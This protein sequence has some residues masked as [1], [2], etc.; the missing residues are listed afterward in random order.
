M[1][2]S[3]RDKTPVERAA[4]GAANTTQIGFESNGAEIACT[5]RKMA[6]NE[7]LCV[8]KNIILDVDAFESYIF[9]AAKSR[10]PNRYAP[11]TDGLSG[12]LTSSVA[13][14]PEE[15][16]L[17]SNPARFGLGGA[18]ILARGFQGAGVHGETHF[19]RHDGSAR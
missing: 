18:Q 16:S 13:T 15:R 19:R 5:F 10:R 8:G 4:C 7:G 6:Y 3:E 14:C 12:V 9:G 11:P 2:K 1:N 17:T